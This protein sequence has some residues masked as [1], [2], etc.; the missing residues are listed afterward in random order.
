MYL[1]SVDM[2]TLILNEQSCS[3]SVRLRNSSK[4]K[5]CPEISSNVLC[6]LLVIKHVLPGFEWDLS[7]CVF[8]N[9]SFIC[10]MVLFRLGNHYTKYS[11]LKC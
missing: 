6:L 8:S 1:F 5:L 4:E 10:L 7:L 9:L 3:L 2:E 11:F